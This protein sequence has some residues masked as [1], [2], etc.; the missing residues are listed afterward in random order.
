MKIQ[1]TI[2]LPNP[3][4]QRLPKTKELDF[5]GHIHKIPPEKRHALT[6]LIF[7]IEEKLQN[8]VASAHATDLPHTL[9]VM[10]TLRPWIEFFEATETDQVVQPCGSSPQLEL[11]KTRRA[12]LLRELCRLHNAPFANFY[13]RAELRAP[14]EQ[15]LQELIEIICKTSLHLSV[16][17]TQSTRIM[18]TFLRTLPQQMRYWTAEHAHRTVHRPQ[19]KFGYPIGH[20]VNILSANDSVKIFNDTMTRA[21]IAYRVLPLD[22][23]NFIFILTAFQKFLED[24]NRSLHDLPDDVIE[25]RWRACSRYFHKTYIPQQIP[26]RIDQSKD[27]GH[28]F[29]IFTKEHM[30]GAFFILIKS[31]ISIQD[32]Q[33]HNHHKHDMLWEQ[34]QK[35][36]VKSNALLLSFVCNER[37]NIIPEPSTFVQHVMTATRPTDEM[38][39]KLSHYYSSGVDSRFNGRYLPSLHSIPE[40]EERQKAKFNAMMGLIN[41]PHHK[42]EFCSQFWSDI[43]RFLDPVTNCDRMLMYRRH[44]GTPLEYAGFSDWSSLQK[45][46]AAINFLKNLN[47]IICEYNTFPSD[48]KISNIY[49]TKSNL[50]AIMPLLDPHADSRNEVTRFSG[51]EDFPLDDMCN[52]ESLQSI[53]AEH[54]DSLFNLNLVDILDRSATFSFL[55]CRGNRDMHY[56][57]PMHEILTL[58]INQLEQA[59]YLFDNQKLN[60]QD[61]HH[62]KL[63]K[64][65]TYQFCFETILV[66]YHLFNPCVVHNQELHS[67]FLVTNPFPRSEK[68][69]ESK[70][71]EIGYDIETIYFH[72][73]LMQY[74]YGQQFLNITVQEI[75][76][77]MLIHIR[78]ELLNFIHKSDDLSLSRMQTMQLHFGLN[79]SGP[80]TQ[81]LSDAWIDNFSNKFSALP[82]FSPDFII[83]Q[84]KIEH[85]NPL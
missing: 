18:L 32:A 69:I 50:S 47:Q 51:M 28:S 35:Q 27:A 66:L 59:G 39:D 56:W 38:I 14:H 43:I 2:Y 22:K 62:Q 8:A 15:T 29:L 3:N 63:F 31:N 23:N 26:L 84:P 20:I 5:E 73:I 44:T 13:Q 60:L 17:K 82:R 49:Y 4:G 10:H 55:N 65:I 80:K 6:L 37:N 24:F 85:L 72:N 48:I 76:T 45:Y 64:V 36:Y 71:G 30:N 19:F 61:P 54:R 67:L 81:V 79:S 78:N 40:K 11:A 34:R 16:H 75:L 70:F 42:T 25:N 33:I 53:P 41:H 9:R 58:D 83:P 12:E 7:Y 1:F 68:E 57:H 74:T 52:F 46:Y 21:T 77:T